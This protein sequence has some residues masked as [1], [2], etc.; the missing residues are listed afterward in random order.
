M[1]KFISYESRL[2]IDGHR[3]NFELWMLPNG[4]YKEYPCD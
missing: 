4:H 1:P 2:D 3:Y